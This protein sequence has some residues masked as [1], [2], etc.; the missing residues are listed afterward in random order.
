MIWFECVYRFICCNC[1]LHSHGCLV[2]RIKVRAHIFPVGSGVLELATRSQSVVAPVSILEIRKAYIR[3][4]PRCLVVL[5]PAA[6][7]VDDDI[8]V[9][10]IRGEA[11]VEDT[12]RASTL[13]HRRA[14][15]V[16]APA[17]RTEPLGPHR[18]DAVRDCESCHSGVNP[19]TPDDEQH[20]GWKSCDMIDADIVQ[21]R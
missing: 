16:H 6:S 2:D 1:L 11:V 9:K 4:V 10:R 8:V 19:W 21:S 18:E 15:P 20:A 13:R 3:T 7:T 5:R 17:G 12:F 14:V